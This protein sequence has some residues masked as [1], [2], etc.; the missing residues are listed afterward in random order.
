MQS[1]FS[2]SLLTWEAPRTVR[3]ITCHGTEPGGG[4]FGT[5]IT[6]PCRRDHQSRGCYHT[7]GS[8]GACGGVGMGTLGAP[9]TAGPMAWLAGE[10]ADFSTAVDAHLM[11]STSAGA[12]FASSG[13]SSTLPTNFD[14]TPL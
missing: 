9:G 4:E 3:P 7:L 11:K 1:W 14:S 6:A 13:G 5:L 10:D 12:L 2:V 8:G